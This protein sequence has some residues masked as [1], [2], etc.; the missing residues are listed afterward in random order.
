MDWEAGV[1]RHRVLLAGHRH[2]N[3]R[4]FSSSLF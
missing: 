3:D 4:Y 1:L 2:H